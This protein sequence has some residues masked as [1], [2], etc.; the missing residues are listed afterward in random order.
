MNQ[1]NTICAHPMVKI[2][3]SQE[4]KCF[5]SLVSNNTLL[6]SSSSPFRN[7]PPSTHKSRVYRNI[8][9]LQMQKPLDHNDMDSGQPKPLLAIPAEIHIFQEAT[10]I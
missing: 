1:D 5:S 9:F 7:S 8:E 3:S 2:L 4:D 10:P 6:L